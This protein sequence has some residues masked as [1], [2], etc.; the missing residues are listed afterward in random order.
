MNRTLTR[1]EQ[2]VVEKAIGALDNTLKHVSTVP[3]DAFELRAALKAALNGHDPVTAEKAIGNLGDSMDLLRETVHAL[4]KSDDLMV[5]LTA[6][7][8]S[9]LVATRKQ[10]Q[11][12]QKE[13]PQQE[14]EKD[15]NSRP[16]RGRYTATATGGRTIP[17]GRGDT[18]YAANAR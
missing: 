11:R 18:G 17:T 7:V 15:G 4:P 8:E 5:A 2:P 1:N 9:G 14:Q 12:Q 6:L 10:E 3:Q 13:P 16:V